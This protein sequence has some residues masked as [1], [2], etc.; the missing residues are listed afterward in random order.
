MQVLLVSGL[1]GAIVG[2]WLYPTWHVAVE[3]AQVVAGIVTYPPD[4]PFY[5]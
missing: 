2:A 5:T 1:I 4:N 3:T